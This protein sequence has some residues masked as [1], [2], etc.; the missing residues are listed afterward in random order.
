M[1][2]IITLIIATIAFMGLFLVFHLSSGEVIFSEYL[3]RDHHDDLDFDFSYCVDESAY[4]NRITDSHWGK[5]GVF[6]IKGTAAQNCGTTWIFGGYELEGDNLILNYT[7]IISSLFAC[8][9]GYPVEFEITGLE[10]REYNI[11]LIEKG[12]VYKQPALLLKLLEL[13]E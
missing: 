2:K 11:T 4:K 12:G 5:D 1:K 3:N 10:K 8:V 13:S 6:S 9:C 7:P